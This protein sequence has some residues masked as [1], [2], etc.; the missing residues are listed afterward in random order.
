MITAST[1]F[2]VVLETPEFRGEAGLRLNPRY[3]GVNRVPTYPSQYSEEAAALDDYIFGNVKSEITNLIPDYA[4]AVD[5]MQRLSCS[6]R[7][8]QLLLCCPGPNENGCEIIK[9]N[10]ATAL[11]YDVALLKGDGWSI[12][13]DFS[14]GEWA[15]GF[16][17]QL[18]ENGLFRHQSDAER[19]LHAYR[20][21]HEPD[22]EMPFEVAFV[23]R[24]FPHGKK[25]D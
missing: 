5:L 16:L 25:S 2:L 14:S 20:E 11:G 8:Y 9:L 15:K 19:Y 22:A 18:N 13:G 17:P 3:A 24:V 6:G 4:T 23:V 12:V 7:R 1:G 21:H 10:E